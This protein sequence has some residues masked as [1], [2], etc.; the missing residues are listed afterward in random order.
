MKQILKFFTFFVLLPSYVFATPNWYYNINSNKPNTYIGFGSAN[1]EQEAKQIALEDISSQISV[2]IDSKTTRT[3]KIIAGD[4]Q[5]NIE[6]KSTQKTKANLSDFKLLKIDLE[7]GTYYVAIEYENI[8]SIDK[9]KAKLKKAGYKVQFTNYIK[10]FELSRK[11]KRWYIKYKDIMQ[12][13]DTRDFEKFFSTIQNK[14][15]QFQ[16]NKINNILYNGDEFYFKVKSS[17]K[18]YITIFDV[19]EDGTV[20]VLYKNVKI[21]ANKL[22]NI[23]NEN[24]EQ[25]PVAGLLEE[26]KDA[27]DLQIALYSDKKLILD[28]FAMASDEIENDERYKNFD[29]LLKFL[30]SKI[31]SSFKMVTKHR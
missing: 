13:L 23:P 15:L 28:N 24:F 26:G 5:K 16:T 21:K 17:K 22:T 14:N 12:L 27:I 25:I 4:Y 30:N 19:Y 10:N 1:S 18:G 6:Q 7:D 9:F 2:Q 29:E 3:K 31:F 20:I 8:P 11:D